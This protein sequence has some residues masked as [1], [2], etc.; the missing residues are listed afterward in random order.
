[1][2]KMK[3]NLLSEKKT[4]LIKAS[5]SLD[6]DVDGDETDEIQGNMLIEL[7]KQ[8]STRDSIKISYIDAALQRIEDQTYGLCQ[9]CGD[10]IPDKRL[11]SNPYFL[12]CVGCAETYEK[13][14]KQRKKL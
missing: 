7:A 1:M 14:I 9:E 10:N 8:F 6:I 2:N 3:E 12:T 11:L 5:Q 4:L 13:E